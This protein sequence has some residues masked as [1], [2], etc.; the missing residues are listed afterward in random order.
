[1]NM[2]K[3]NENMI[4][5]ETLLAAAPGLPRYEDIAHRGKIGRDLIE[6]FEKDMTALDEVLAWEYCH[7]NGKP[8]SDEELSSFDYSIFSQCLIHVIWRS[9]PDATSLLEG[10]TAFGILQKKRSARSVKKKSETKGQS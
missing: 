4:S 9:Y 5:V 6:P 1:M 10:R 8:L 3:T 7:S 2:G